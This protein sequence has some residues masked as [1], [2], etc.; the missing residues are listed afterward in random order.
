MEEQQVDIE[1]V[2]ANGQRVFL[3]DEGEIPT[4]LQKNVS[5]VR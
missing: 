4:E 1:R 5:Q 2:V 3:A